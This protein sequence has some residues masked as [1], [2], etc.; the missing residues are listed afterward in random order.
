MEKRLVKVAQ[1]L[2]IGTERIVEYLNS[3][4]HVIENKPTSK[5][6]PE[7]ENL[8]LKEFSKFVAE[9]EAADKMTIGNR[10]ILRREIGQKKDEIITTTVTSPPPPPL[11]KPK[12]DLQHRQ[13][14]FRKEEPKP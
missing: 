12:E 8:L 7:M 14:L 2:N 5:V 4:G 3:H 9:K 6:T 11:F 10:T 1:E 13:P